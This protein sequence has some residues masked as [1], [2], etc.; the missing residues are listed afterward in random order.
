MPAY[1]CGQ[2]VEPAA[3]RI[4]HQMAKRAVFGKSQFC[5]PT[6]PISRKFTQNRQAAAV[7]FCA[8]VVLSRLRLLN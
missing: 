4:Y 6:T 2:I 7:P 8:G 1:A 5:R 3:G